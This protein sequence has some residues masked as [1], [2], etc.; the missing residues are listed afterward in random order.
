MLP[1]VVECPDGVQQSQRTIDQST[2][3]R[4][5]DKVREEIAIAQIELHDAGLDELD[6]EGILGF[7]DH[8]LT[9][10]ARLWL[11]AS[12]DQKQRLQRVE[13]IRPPRPVRGPQVRP[14]R[15]Q[16]IRPPRLQQIRRRRPQL[17]SKFRW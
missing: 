3:D 6:V 13:Q 8:I 17:L 5:R 12:L 1:L 7:A 10:A 14:P 2:C 4:Q 15:A 16:Q 11:E 9:N